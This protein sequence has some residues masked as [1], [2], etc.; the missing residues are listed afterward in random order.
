MLPKIYYYFQSLY[1][2]HRLPLRRRSPQQMEWNS[3]WKWLWRASKMGIEWAILRSVSWS[4]LVWSK[5]DPD[6]GDPGLRKIKFKDRRSD[7][8]STVSSLSWHS[9]MGSAAMLKRYSVPIST[10]LVNNGWFWTMCLLLLM[11]WYTVPLS[12][13]EFQDIY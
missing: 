1:P 5:V 3:L 7:R 11:F 6:Q 12:Q 10:C 13:L 4:S 9:H 2:N 8:C